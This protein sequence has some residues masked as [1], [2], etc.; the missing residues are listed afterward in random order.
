MRTF[1]YLAAPVG[2][3]GALISCDSLWSSSVTDCGRSG[4]KCPDGYTPP[5]QDSD[6]SMNG[7]DSG[8]GIGDMGTTGTNDMAG[9][10]PTYTSIYILGNSQHLTWLGTSNG[11]LQSYTDSSN[12]PI[13]GISS[14]DSAGSAIVGL[15]RGD[16][17]KYADSSQRTLLIVASQNKTIRHYINGVKGPD[18]TSGQPINGMWVGAWNQQA[19]NVGYDAT[20]IHILTVGDA[21]Q[22]YTGK[23]LP[24]AQI[25]WGGPTTLPGGK[26]LN[27]ISGHSSITTPGIVSTPCDIIP[28]PPNCD[29]NLAWAVG[30]QGGLFSYKRDPMTSTFGWTEIP[31]FMGLDG[32]SV[33]LAVG[34]SPD[35][36]RVT[37]AGQGGTSVE[38][39]PPPLDA[40]RALVPSPFAG[41]I[42]AISYCDRDEAYAV[43]DNSAVY[44]WLAAIY[45]G[46]ATWT[47]VNITL[48][49]QPL[50][51]VDFRAVHCAPKGN[52]PSSR[53]GIVGSQGTF[54]FADISD[55]R[56]LGVWQKVP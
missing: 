31:S 45:G 19:P 35:E 28:K 32:E 21:G 15:W 10:L 53:V 27:S 33:F 25:T 24:D 46:S 54:L 48:A 8:S 34:S 49:G 23:I 42:R 47:P 4:F 51:G 6:M 16:I 1:L 55:G 50:T 7:S 17:V 36:P 52:S 56:S 39:D 38:R 5:G 44:R 2:L 13:K 3:I 12:F 14:N 41:T 29:D 43:G 30:N 9:L 20:E 22:T 26:K 11:F 37:T 40:W 18:F